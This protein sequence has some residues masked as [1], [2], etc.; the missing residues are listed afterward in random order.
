MALNGGPVF[1][2][3]E[4]VSLVVNC[5]TQSEL[6]LYWKKLTA[7]GEE[8]ACGWLKDKFGLSWQVVPTVVAKM[9]QDKDPAK[10]NRVMQAILQMKKLDL[11]RLKKAYQGARLRILSR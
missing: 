1:K 3:S 8:V 2:L 6:D 4:A 10:S 7:G 9:I 5:K 11:K